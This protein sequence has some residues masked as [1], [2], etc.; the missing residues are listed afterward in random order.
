MGPTRFLDSSTRPNQ[1]MRG[2]GSD[3]DCS[4]PSNVLYRVRPRLSR[5]W[6]APSTT[7]KHAVNLE[8]P[9]LTRFDSPTRS[10]P[11]SKHLHIAGLVAVLRVIC[12]MRHGNAP[13]EACLP[14]ATHV[15]Q[16]EDTQGDG[17]TLSCTGV[18]PRGTSSVAKVVARSCSP[19]QGNGPV[20][21]P[22]V[23]SSPISRPA[24]GPWIQE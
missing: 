17:E 3:T 11:S 15:V 19:Y 20:H 22:S 2:P 6:P 4:R 13:L 24:V 9:P 5:P 14:D 12:M 1:R 8:S 16:N 23:A 7:E 21:M 10:R 18:S